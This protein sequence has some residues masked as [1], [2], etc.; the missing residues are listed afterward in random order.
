[1]CRNLNIT[2]RIL[3]VSSH[4]ILS[5]SFLPAV[6]SGLAAVTYDMG[7]LAGDSGRL[8]L[9]DIIVFQC[10]DGFP[11]RVQ[12]DISIFSSLKKQ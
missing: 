6:L 11:Q 5:P 4:S 10:R 9:N 12:L 8:S 3:F 1:M 2:R 7:P